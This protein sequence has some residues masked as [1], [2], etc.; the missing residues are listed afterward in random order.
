MMMHKSRFWILDDKGEP[1]PVAGIS[2]WSIA[3]DDEKAIVK[4]EDVSGAR[5]S[6]VFLGVDHSFTQTGPP[7]LWETMVFGGMLDM[8]KDRCGGTREQAEAMHERVVA[9]VKANQ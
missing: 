9:K 1:K 7:I 8:Y 6:T 2:E 5:I 3:T 4:Q